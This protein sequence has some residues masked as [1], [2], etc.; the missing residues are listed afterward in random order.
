MP[1]DTLPDRELAQLLDEQIDAMQ[2]VLL[3]L[4]SERDALE[5]G[6]HPGRI[7]FVDGRLIVAELF[8]V[9]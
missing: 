2:S 4:E 7:P 6:L 8:Q 1:R 9:V 3:A 5:S